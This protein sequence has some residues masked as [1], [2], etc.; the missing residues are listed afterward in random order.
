MSGARA[1]AGRV[2][3]YSIVGCPHC[4][5]AKF[6]LQ[7]KSIPFTEVS[8]DQYNPTVREQ[9]QKATGSNT[10]PQIYFNSVHVGGNIELQK[11]VRAFGYY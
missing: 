10:V 1:I 3:I 8:I 2:T 4:K 7:E 6:S 5:A 9:V 11:A